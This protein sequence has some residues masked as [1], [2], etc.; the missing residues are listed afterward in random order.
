MVFVAGLWLPTEGRLPAYAFTASDLL[1][2]VI[3]YPLLWLGV[4]LPLHRVGARN[5]Y[6]YGIYIYPFPVTQ[7]LAIWGAWR[8][9][10]PLFSLLCV[11]GTIPFAVASWW[12][13]EKRALSL[14]KLDPKATLARTLGPKPEGPLQMENVSSIE[15]GTSPP[16][17]VSS[18]Q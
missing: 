15:I 13:I 8:L 11:I 18:D 2:P 14:K 6:S 7:L 1:A 12:V 9:G 5:D 16:A 4:H 10:Y 3:A 17:D